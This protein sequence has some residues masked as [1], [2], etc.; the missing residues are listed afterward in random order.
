MKRRLFVI[1]LAALA[2]WPAAALAQPVESRAYAL[3]S[4]D[5]IEVGGSAVVRFAQGS[6]DEVI[7]EGDDA[8]QKA[9]ELEVRNGTL[10]IH[11]GGAWKFW[12]AR[13]LQLLVTARTLKRVTISGA[14]DLHAPSPV[15]ADKLSI[16]ISG[17]GS[18]RFDQLKAEQLIFQ[19]S[20]AGDGQI[21]G[22]AKV[23]SVRIAGKS[24]F[25]GGKLAS[26]RARVSISGVGNVEVWAA[27][28]LDISV[29]GIGTVDYWGAPQVKRSI[30]GRAEINERGA[31]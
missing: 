4:F 5:S 2:H 29:A 22:E 3:G 15:N 13:R 12:N 7:V 17:A 20:G 28:Q 18:A 21:A 10:N 19:V 23:L 31:K 11:R 8:M 30:S 27:Q 24:N 1:C 9:V 16:D 14:A 6:R 25:N 26:E